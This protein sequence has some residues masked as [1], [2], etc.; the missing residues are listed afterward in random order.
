VASFTRSGPFRRGYRSADVDEFFDNARILY[1]EDDLPDEL[2]AERVRTLSF[3]LVRNGYKTG[4]VDRALERL[5]RACWQRERA[6]VV[7]A[8]GTDA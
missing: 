2:D 3:P 7:A 5:E 8:E 1:Q 4:E 6:Q